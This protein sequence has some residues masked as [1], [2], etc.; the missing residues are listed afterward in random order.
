MLKRCKCQMGR[1]IVRTEDAI[2]AGAAPGM[3]C[4]PVAS[5]LN[6]HQE[7]VLVAIGAEVHDGLDLA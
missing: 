4:P 7:R 5:G 6:A 3:A 1:P 2:E